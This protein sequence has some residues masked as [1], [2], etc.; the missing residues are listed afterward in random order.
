MKKFYILK[1]NHYLITIEIK[2]SIRRKK[3]LKD[4]KNL[5]LEK[6]KIN[7]KTLTLKIKMIIVLKRKNQNLEQIWNFPNEKKQP[8][9]DII[10]EINSRKI[11]DNLR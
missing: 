10:K 5:N 3:D 8:L 2:N 6:K 11:K 1:K 7:L 4:Q 9:I